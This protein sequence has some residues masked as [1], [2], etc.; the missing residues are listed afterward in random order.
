MYKFGLP[1]ANH[2]SHQLVRVELDYPRRNTVSVLFEDDCLNAVLALYRM[3]IH[4]EDLVTCTKQS[5]WQRHACWYLICGVAMLNHA[6]PYRSY[7][8]PAVADGRAHDIRSP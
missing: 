2:P 6:I 8:S 1:N 5:A 3:G 4:A 7:P